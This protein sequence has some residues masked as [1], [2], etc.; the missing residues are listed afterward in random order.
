MKKLYENIEDVYIKGD[1]AQLSEVVKSMDALLQNIAAYTEQLTDYLVKYS[2]TNNGNQYRKVVDTCMTLRDVLFDAS[3]QLNDMQNQIVAYQNKIYR[4]EDMVGYAQSANPCFIIKR[5]V[6]LE[7]SLIQFNLTDMIN[8]TETLEN[9]KEQM[10]YNLKL[11]NEKKNEIASVWQDTQ[12]NI[13]AEFINDVI[14]NS[15]DAIQVFE[16]YILYLKEKIKELSS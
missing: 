7:A 10:Y 3:Y 2:V 6:Q 8:L 12:Y 1:I 15:V 14:K 9:Y 4:Y 13:F 5:Q 11:I 16:E